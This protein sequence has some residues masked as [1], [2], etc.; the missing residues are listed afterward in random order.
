MGLITAFNAV[1]ECLVT[2]LFTALII[3][4]MAKI[5]WLPVL[6]IQEVDEEEEEADS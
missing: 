5:G 2:G 4:G 6:F 1:L 3:L